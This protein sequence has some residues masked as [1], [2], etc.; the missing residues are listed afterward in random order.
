MS[1]VLFGLQRFLVFQSTAFS[2]TQC[3]FKAF[4]GDLARR[5]ARD[6]IVDGGMVID[7]EYLYAAT[8]AKARVARVPVVW[9]P[10]TRQSKINVRKA[11]RQDPI[12]LVRIK[13]NGLRGRYR[14]GES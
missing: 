10:E 11:V 4:S 12:D 7:I 6:Q 5:L 1:L 3:G 9:T 2:D 13:W 14:G 8:L